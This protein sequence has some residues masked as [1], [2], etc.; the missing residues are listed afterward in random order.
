MTVDGSAFNKTQVW[1]AFAEGDA[2]ATKLLQRMYFQE[3]FQPLTDIMKEAL[4]CSKD[5]FIEKVQ[6]ALTKPY[7]GYKQADSI[8]KSVITYT[9]GKSMER[10]AD[11]LKNEI[12]K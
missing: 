4:A 2:V 3:H 7:E 5:A 10:V 6:E 11:T 12:F 1:P 8:L 9:D